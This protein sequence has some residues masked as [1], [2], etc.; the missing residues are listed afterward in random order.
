MKNKLLLIIWITF[1]F[2]ATGVAANK[3]F[4]LVI[5]AGHG[6]ND[7]GARGSVSR[8]KDLTLRYALAFGEMVERNSPDVKVIYTRKTDKFVELYKRAEIANNAKADLFISI[9]INSLPKGHVARGFQTYTLGTSKRTGKKTGVLENLEVAKRENAVIFMEKDYKQTYQGYDPNSPESN[10]MFEFIQ[11]KN[12]EM[13]VELAKFMQRR[14]CR[15]TGRQDMGAQQDNLA[16]LRLTS[17]PGC[18]IELGFISTR[19]EETFMNSDAARQKYA[20]G[21]YQAFLDYKKKYDK[22]ISV[23]YKAETKTE[24][25]IPAVVP[26]QEAKPEKTEKAEKPKKKK[27]KMA[28][29]LAEAREGKDAA[30]ADAKQPAVST[31]SI[32]MEPAGDAGTSATA[33][34]A[35]TASPAPA[36]AAAPSSVKSAAPAATSSAPIFKVQVL[37]SATKLKAGDAQ[38]KG[39]RDVDSYQEGG[40]YKY[41]VGAS[42]DYNEIYQLRKSLLT[43]F[44]QAFIIAF[45]DGKKVDVRNAIQEYKANKK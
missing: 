3:K 21:I 45:K 40:M 38:L 32:V 9:H 25:N 28:Q 41:T 20:Q 22:N 31:D 4:T 35:A 37:A 43:S 17:M 13:S 7:P 39:Q 30:V 29:E 27:S 5:D 42:A 36:P 23:P 15:A 2:A 33:A 12:M 16:V 11:D 19:D 8:E 24:V 1:A 6:G 26:Q 44:P 14:V 18:L 10:I 34:K